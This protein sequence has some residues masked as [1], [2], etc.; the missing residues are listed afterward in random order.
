MPHES[1]TLLVR[2]RRA[3]GDA[4]PLF[5]DQPLELVR[6][7]GVWVYDAEGRRYLDC[8]NNVPHV[9]HCHPRVV[10]AIQQ[11]VATLNL[12]T[13]YLHEKVVRYA[14]ELASTVAID[15][16]AVMFTCTGT[17]ANELA[18]RMAEYHTGADG[19]IVSDFSYHG[20]SR[21]LAALTSCFETPEPFPSRARAIPIPDPFRDRQGR[22]DEALASA[23]AAKV[24]AAIASLKADGHGVSA[25]LIDA[26]F[27]NEGLPDP[28]P[29]FVAKA[30]ELVRKAGG[31]VIFD[32]V[33]AGFGRTG[34][35]MWSHQLHGVTPD[36]V[37][38]GKPMGNGF[39]VAGLIAPKGMVDRFGGQAN[40]FNTFGGNPVAAAA[41][42]AVLDVLREDSLLDRAALVS[43]DVVDGL[44]RL[45]LRYPQIANVR[46]RGMFFGLELTRNDAVRT[47]D[48]QLAKRIVEGMKAAGVLMGRIG[49]HD[50]I[51]KLRPAM[52]FETEHAELLI[53]RLGQVLE[54]VA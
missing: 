34:R 32:E 14:E 22:D 25:M 12:N 53:D 50:N 9:G 21:Q 48:P 18:L 26:S 52:V 5:Y 1:S 51:L 40:Y 17:E 3:M 2:R 46:S 8:Y 27:A 23:F 15:P 38:M 10:A 20:N 11:Q 47:P 41:G 37:T 49:R 42:Q 4:A 39:P 29:G 44:D 24:E 31:L 16:A 54:D 30:V 45:Q 13:R 7:E 6:G 33:Q 36:I 35:A 19:V 28:V 43:R